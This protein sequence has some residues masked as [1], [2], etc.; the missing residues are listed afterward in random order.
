MD[1][2]WTFSRAKSPPGAYNIILRGDLMEGF[3]LYDFGELIH[4]GAYFWNFTVFCELYMTVF[5]IIVGP[6]FF[7]LECSVFLWAK[8]DPH[9]TSPPSLPFSRYMQIMVSRCKFQFTHQSHLQ[10]PAIKHFCYI[11]TRTWGRSAMNNT[12]LLFYSPKHQNGPFESRVKGESNSWSE[13]NYW[14]I[15]LGTVLS[16]CR[17]LNRNW[18]RLLTL[19]P[20]VSNL[21]TA[22]PSLTWYL[23][24]C[25]WPRVCKWN[26]W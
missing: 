14:A 26:L 17:S 12:F 2:C 15:F 9:P 5:N 10:F 3:L 19:D 13:I 18:W 16:Y 20:G 23:T 25:S 21:T 4:G 22:T 24:H 6:T 11:K 7:V 1:T 8:Q